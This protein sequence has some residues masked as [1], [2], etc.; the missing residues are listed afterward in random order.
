MP[1]DVSLIVNYRRGFIC[2]RPSLKRE[3]RIGPATNAYLD[4]N[5]SSLEET[6][7]ASKVVLEP[8]IGRINNS[9]R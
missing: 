8:G 4:G 5:Q 2:H 1:L 3:R 9:P 7:K 6:T